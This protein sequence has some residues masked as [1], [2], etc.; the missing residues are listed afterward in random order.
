M[1]NNHEI[2]L[3]V[4]SVAILPKRP[5]SDSLSPLGADKHWID[6]SPLTDVLPG[7]ECKRELNQLGLIEKSMEAP[8]LQRDNASRRMNL[9]R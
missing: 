3:G 4:P 2:F 8:P 1:D 9:I 7:A 5:Q 6:R